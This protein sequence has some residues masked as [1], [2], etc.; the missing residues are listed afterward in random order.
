MLKSN[1]IINRFLFKWK[2]TIQRVTD[3]AIFI[4]ILFSVGFFIY[5]YGFNLS[6]YEKM[7]VIESSKVV[8]ITFVLAGIV[9]WLVET[10][11]KEYFQSSWLELFL[12]VITA[13]H[14]AVY[15]L[16][17]ISFLKKLVFSLT[18]DVVSNIVYQYAITFFILLYIGIYLLR[19]S[20]KI[21]L[22][23]VKPAV[24][25][26]SS[27]IVLIIIGTSLLKLP[28]M[29]VSGAKLSWINATFTAASAS[30]VTGLSVVDTGT[31]FTLKGQLVILV[32][33]QLGGIGIVTFA[34][35]FALVLTKGF[36]IKQQSILQDFL[37]TENLFTTKGLL[38]R[39]IVITFII[40]SLGAILIYLSWDSTLKF[41]SEAQKVFF[42]IFHSVSAFCNAGFSLFPDSLHSSMLSDE[43]TLF[44]NVGMDVNIREMFGLHF[45]I[46]L[47]I[48]MGS[49]GFT[50]IEDV[51]PFRRIEGKFHVIKPIK[52][53]KISTK[54]I[55]YA[56]ALLIGIGFLLFFTL[57]FNHLKDKTLPNAL[58]TALFQSITLRTAG[59]NTLDFASL[60][61]P[62]T[63]ICIF[64]MFIGAAPGSTGGGIKSTTFYVLLLS[65]IA[66]IRNSEN[67]E[68]G[69]RTIP[70]GIINRAYSIFLFA[71]TYNLI[72]IFILSITE[73][74]SGIEILP[75]VFE[76]ISAFATVGLSMGATA[77]LTFF[78]K[79][80]IIFSM[81]VGRVG[82]L[83]LALALSSQV[84]TTSY[85]YPTVNIMVG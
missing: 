83:T 15:Y 44:S 40:E 5:R 24:T 71:T 60:S 45:S 12:T 30:C 67:I 13:V 50:V 29:T 20:E 47:L 2:D 7:K 14:G 32:L 26:L 43:T 82:T 64:L 25:F 74:E 3:L 17:D 1:D 85:K 6:S 53:W 23:E 56:T 76:Q 68:V 28:A 16:F 58:V 62:T 80:V 46:G 59:F 52:Q 8:L 63:I 4:N 70:N 81:Y 34:T 36:G 10:K 73:R 69:K 72:A 33:A 79:M 48:I 66:S 75:L 55:M 42:S 18:E 54:I 57:E 51:F 9:R 61:I 38:R 78:G 11:K 21:A 41:D 77:S 39:V 35:F 65:A 19:Y 49:I 31:F 84:K 22:L 37:S 27:F